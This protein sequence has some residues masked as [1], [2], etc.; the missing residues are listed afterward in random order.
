MASPGLPAGGAVTDEVFEARGTDRREDV[1]S[2]PGKSH[3]YNVFKV[4]YTSY[5]SPSHKDDSFCDK[6][7]HQNSVILIYIYI[8]DR[9]VDIVCGEG[10]WGVRA[11]ACVCFNDATRQKEVH[12]RLLTMIIGFKKQIN[13]DLIIKQL[14][15]YI[16]I[17][18]L[19]HYPF[20]CLRI[21]I[22]LLRLRGLSKCFSMDTMN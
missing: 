11:P 20:I 14:S 3:L 15:D 1:P 16:T 7:A 2:D 17:T 12:P 21:I 4:T 10:G 6:S 19:S 22:T 13:E 8:M 5:S 18:D 9:Y